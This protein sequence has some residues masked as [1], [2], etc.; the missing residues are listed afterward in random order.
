MRN[1]SLTLGIL[2]V[3]WKVQ[4]AQRNAFVAPVVRERVPDG[5]VH[6]ILGDVET[7]QRDQRYRPIGQLD[8]QVTR[9]RHH[10]R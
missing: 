4:E 9:P 3:G 1:L 5:H 8:G 6:G 7:G 10:G 2:E